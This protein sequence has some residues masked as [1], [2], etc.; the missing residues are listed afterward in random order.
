MQ[1]FLW[2]NYFPGGLFLPVSRW[3]AWWLCVG[4]LIATSSKRTMPHNLPSRSAAARLT[5]PTAGHCWPVPPQETLIYSKTG[6]TKTHGVHCSFS[7]VLVHTSWYHLFCLHPPSVSDLYEIYFKC[8]FAPSTILL[9]FLLCPWSQGT[10]FL[11][12]S[13]IPLSMV[14]QQ[15]V[16]FFVFSRRWAHLLLFWHLD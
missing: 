1:E 11:V 8:D 3:S 15:L 9:S 12:V 13:N 7:W 6:L 4:G 5:V 14:V 2:Y 16:V 10:V